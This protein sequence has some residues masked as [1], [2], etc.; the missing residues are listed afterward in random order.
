[1]TDIF[2]SAK[3]RLSRANEHIFSLEKKINAFIETEPYILVVESD[4][5]GVNQLHK[6]KFTK[7][8]FDEFAAIVADAVDNLRSSLDLAWYVVA[9]ASKAIRPTGEAP[10]PFADKASDFERKIGGCKYFPP[11]I[12]G[13]LRE[14]KP[15]K[16]GD[17]LLW[18][19]NRICAANKHRMLAPVLANV[20]EMA[21]HHITIRGRGRIE[22][23]L[24]RWDRSKNEIV[25]AITK[26]DERIEYDIDFGF[27]IAF[28]EVVIVRNQPVLTVLNALARKVEGI[29]MGLEAE[30]RRL[31]YI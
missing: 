29:L 21:I 30:A 4:P 15:Y 16:G 6:I 13:L 24:P 25:W 18:A 3:L 11:E 23:P 7:P 12:L 31:G 27:D 10:F 5:S 28:D 8:L 1:M 26:P 14:F 9:I 17:D 22:F 20:I 2:H 19:L